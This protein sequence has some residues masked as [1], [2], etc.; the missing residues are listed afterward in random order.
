MV[1]Q[2]QCRPANAS[3]VFRSNDVS[4][5]SC[6]EFSRVVEAVAKLLAE[7]TRRF[8]YVSD[9]AITLFI[10]VWAKQAGRRI[11]WRGFALNAVL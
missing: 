7:E 9:V 3:R 2:V 10:T 8:I 6:C 11:R 4:Q 5:V 1:P